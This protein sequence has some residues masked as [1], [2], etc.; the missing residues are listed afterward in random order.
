MAI[1]HMH[2]EELSS[3]FPLNLDAGNQDFNI[4]F[5]DYIK[6][7]KDTEAYMGEY[8]ITPKPYVSQTLN[9]ANKMMLDD[10]LVFQI[11]YFETSNTNGTTVYIGNE[12]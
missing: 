9:T 12:V 5:G 8:E 10:I 6:V 11:P 2:M 4:S 3:S 1:F 7:D